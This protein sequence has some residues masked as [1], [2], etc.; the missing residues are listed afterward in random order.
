MRPTKFPTPSP[1]PTLSD[2]FTFHTG[3]RIRYV[4]ARQG[5]SVTWLTHSLHCVR[6]NIYD[7]FARRSIDTLLLLRISLLLGHDFLSEL[8]AAVRA[9]PEAFA[10]FLKNID[11]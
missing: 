9:N 6:T 5:R 7:I 11:H 1:P 10:A 2:G 3:R 8:S 4:L